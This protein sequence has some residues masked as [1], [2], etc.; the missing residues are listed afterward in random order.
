[1]SDIGAWIPL[2]G[3]VL[4]Y[5]LAVWLVR[6]YISSIK[7]DIGKDLESAVRNIKDNI[8]TQIDFCNGRFDSVELTDKEQW[9]AINSHGHKGLD[10]NGSKVTRG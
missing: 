2:A 5:G 8:N 6:S 9:S 10:S 4:V 7:I 1:M 3:N